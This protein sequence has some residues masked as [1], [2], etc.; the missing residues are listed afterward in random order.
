M[1]CAILTLVL[2]TAGTIFACK[3]ETPE[4]APPLP[5]H[6]GVTLIQPGVPPYQAL[7][8]HLT[9][10][11]RTT[12]RLICDLDV[13]NDGHSGPM[14]ALVVDLDTTV[15][16]ILADG[17]AKLR[18]TV[19]RTSIRDRP[20]SPV[21]SDM[22]LAQATAMQ[23]IV[24]T[25]TLAP[26]GQLADP[27]VEAASSVP[28]SAREQLDRLSKSLAQVAMRMPSEPVGIG[29]TWR[30]RRTLP[31]GGIRAVSETLYTLTS[32]TGDVM[33]YTNVGLST[34][35]PQTIEQDG[36]KVEVT[37]TH[38]HSQA[39]G[40]VDLSRYA[41][42]VASTSSFATAMNVVAPQ[43]TPGAGPSTVEITMAIHVMPA[44]GPRPPDD[45]G[46]RSSQ[47]PDAITAA[48]GQSAGA[49]TAGNGQ[50]P[51]AITADH[52]QPPTANAAANDHPT[53]AITAGE[54]QPPAANAAGT[55]QPAA[56][57]G[58]AQGSTPTVGRPPQTPPAREGPPAASAA[59]ISGITAAANRPA[60]GPSPP[61]SASGTTSPPTN[62]VA[63][64]GIITVLRRW[65]RRGQLIA[66]HRTR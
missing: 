3:P 27:H 17:S 49:I 38:G 35:A 28:D 15:E 25:E 19:V 24:F 31:D 54:G 50:P 18:V 10:G 58:N 32:F 52:G 43:G 26:D 47:P 40:S 51:G 64:H 11:T 2:V 59:T 36:M 42:D 62:G 23:G 61:P 7:R 29:A 48:N 21:S 53:P 16:D 56:T 9:R 60:P 4:P 41:F 65:K 30:E 20:G 45:P 63:R 46:A 8:Y 13:K 12:S 6:D 34:G 57:A 44:E 14:P 39:K 5:P 1:R 66:P 33:T 22:V 55:T 37:N